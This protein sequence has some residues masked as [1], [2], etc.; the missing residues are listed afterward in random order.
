MHVIAEETIGEATD[1]EAVEGAFEE[2]KVAFTVSS[3]GE[4]RLLRVAT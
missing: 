2:L 3:V 4:D 1:A